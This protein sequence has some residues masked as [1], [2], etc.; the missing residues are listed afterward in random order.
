MSEAYEYGE[1]EFDQDDFDEDD[2]VRMAILEAEANEVWLEE[3]GD[4]EEENEA[5]LNP[6]FGMFSH[7]I[8]GIIPQQTEEK[9]ENDENSGQ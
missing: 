8:P 4:E 1:D 6:L 3:P 5:P 7:G 9:K 2:E